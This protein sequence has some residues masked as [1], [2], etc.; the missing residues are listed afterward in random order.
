MYRVLIG[1]VFPSLLLTL[2]V[3]SGTAGAAP[4]QP[5]SASPQIQTI[6][7]LQHLETV[8][9]KTATAF[10]LYSVLARD[11]QQQKKMQGELEAGNDLVQKLGT[12]AAVS[13]KWNDFKRAVS[14]ARFTSEGVADNAS[15]NAIDAAL[16]ALTQTLRSQATEQRTAGNVVTDKM[17]DMLY[18]QYVLMQVMTSAYLRKSADYFGGAV[19]ATQG[20]QVEIDQLANKFTAQL[21]QLNRYYAKHAEIGPALKEVTTKWVFIRNSFINFNQNQVPFIVGRY[22]EQITDRLLA[23]YEKLL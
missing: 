10:Y 19:V 20:P 17:A 21:D 3:M 18:D 6:R 9:Y 14:T 23:A 15:I 13:A 11:P 5:A 1:L 8:S 16:N 7:T 2:A 4:S 22:N 12:N